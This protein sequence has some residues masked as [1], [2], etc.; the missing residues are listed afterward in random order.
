M[1]N[2]DVIIVGG[3]MVG[4]TAGAMFAKENYKIAIIEPNP[5]TDIDTA[6]N[7]DFRGLALSVITQKIF[8]FYGLWDHVTK[9]CTSINQVHVSK[10]GSIGAFSWRKEEFNNVTLGMV[11]EAG[12]LTYTLQQLCNSMKNITPYWGQRPGGC[13]F[14]GGI[15]NVELE[16]NIIKAPLL[17]ATDGINSSLRDILSIDLEVKDFNQVAIVANIEINKSNYNTAFKR[18]C[19]DKS[20]A[21]VPYK[22][23][24]MKS[25]LIVDDATARKL[26]ELDVLSYTALLNSLMPRASGRII[27]LGKRISYPLQQRQIKELVNNNCVFLGSSAITIHPVAAQ[28]FN[29]AVRD[30]ASLVQV[31]KEEKIDVALEK[32]SAWR[33]KDHS[34]ILK[35][36]NE[37]ISLF[38]RDNATA[39]MF[40]TMGMLAVRNSNFLRKKLMDYMLGRMGVLPKAALGEECAV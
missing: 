18:F 19:E 40:S 37:I 2:Y 28:G 21:L 1:E 3:G 20:L 15:W 17:L 16:G 11:I 31:L 39:K 27:S 22:N 10:K 13:T 34:S 14:E 30:I 26:C 5:I 12:T 23:N 32:Y 7:I 9:E 38:S 35:S 25:I 29:L 36:T 24:M 8:S 33:K 6:N 4:A